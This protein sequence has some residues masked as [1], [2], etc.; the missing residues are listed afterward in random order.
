MKL[1]WCLSDS[2]AIPCPAVFPGHCRDPWVVPS[3]KP[4]S[5]TFSLAR[6]ILSPIPARLHWLQILHDRLLRPSSIAKAVRIPVSNLLAQM[7]IIPRDYGFIIVCHQSMSIQVLN[8]SYSLSSSMCRTTS[9]K[10]RWLYYGRTD[11]GS[12]YKTTRNVSPAESIRYKQSCPGV[13]HL[14]NYVAADS[15]TPPPGKGHEYP[16]PDAT[17]VRIM[18]LLDRSNTW[19]IAIRKVLDL[20]M[21]VIWT[22]SCRRLLRTHMTNRRISPKACQKM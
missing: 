12:R 4:S 17:W 16:T 1:S 22:M 7:I 11:C 13:Q 9:V 6:T 14:S 5:T 15:S 10:S 8:M 18:M 21:V 20:N 2:S 3:I 19:S